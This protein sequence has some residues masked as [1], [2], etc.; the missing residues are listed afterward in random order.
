MAEHGLH[1]PQI[2]TPFEQVGREGVAQDVGRDALAGDARPDRDGPQTLEEVLSR[3]GPTPAPQEHR[4][5]RPR[6]RTGQGRATLAEVALQR[7]ASRLSQRCDAL[8]AS[9]ARDA[10]EARACIQGRQRQLHQLAHAEPRAIEH[11]EHGVIALT[12]QRPV[13]GSLQER[14]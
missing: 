8:L 1:G 2:G 13:V 10:Q 7:L 6:R 14:E 9:L 3:H 4:L 5:V 11:L 12:Q